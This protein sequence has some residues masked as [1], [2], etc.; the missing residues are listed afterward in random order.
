MN[1]SVLNGMS[2]SE[3][4]TTTS[5]AARTLGIDLNGGVRG[6][7]VIIAADTTDTS[8]E[9]YFKLEKVTVCAP[10]Y[11]APVAKASIGDFVWEDK[12]YNGVQDAGE[13]GIANVT[14]KLLS[15]ANTVLAT[16][17]TDSQ[18]RLPVQQPEP[19]RLQGAGGAPSGYYVTKQNQGSDNDQGQRHRQ[20]RHHRGGVPGGGR[21]RS[22]RRCW[23]VPEGLGR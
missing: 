19:G 5:S 20:Q 13:N 11:C 10:D 2:F 9:D 21:E 6:N 23:S 4:N 22:Q 8:P 18:R 16:T 1:N 15:S 14:V 17:T 7:V 12:N 3:V